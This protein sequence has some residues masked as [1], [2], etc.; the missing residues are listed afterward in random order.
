MVQILGKDVGT[1][2]YGLMGLTWR[3]TPCSQ[4]QAFAA[5]KA[6]LDA[7]M[8]FWN[9]GEFYGTPEYNSLHLLSAYFD[10]YPEDAS[11]VVLSIKGGLTPSFK[12]DGSEENLRKCINYCHSFLKGKKTIDLYE[13]ARVDKDT[14]IEETMKTLEKLV[15]EGLI[16][17][18]AMSEVGAETI[19]RAAAVTKIAAVEV[20]LSLWVTDIFHNGIAAACAENNIPVV[21]YSPIG[22]G[23]LTGQFTSPDDLP[24]GDIRK[25]QPWFQP[26][27]FELNLNLVKDLE[28]IAKQ[29]GCTPAQLA[30]SWVRQQSGKNGNPVII[31]IP[32]ATTDKRVLENSKNIS[33]SSSELSE[34]NEVLSKTQ[35]KGERYGAQQIAL[36]NG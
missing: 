5:M 6:S 14:P 20:E 8:N 2:G 19:K 15:K 33:L 22:R 27:I 29:K 24:E 31:P 1:T 26:D 3:P 30:I 9:A 13:M 36:I 34:I 35:V 16:G 32:G 18:I 17:G 23:M 11:K 28:K 7:G 4:E 25:H 21:A 12:P 10:K